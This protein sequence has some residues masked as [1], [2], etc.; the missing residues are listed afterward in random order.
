MPG[1]NNECN[2]G[3][4]AAVGMFLTEVDEVILLGGS[5]PSEGSPCGRHLAAECF[6]P[7]VQRPSVR[8]LTHLVDEVT[9]C[10][11]EYSSWKA[12]ALR[13]AP[14]G[15]DR[16]CGRHLADGSVPPGDPVPAA[17]G[18]VT[19]PNGITAKNLTEDCRHRPLPVYGTFVLL[20]SWRRRRTPSNYIS[21]LA[22]PS[23]KAPRC[24]KSSRHRRPSL[25]IPR[26]RSPTMTAST[27]PW[28]SRRRAMP[29]ASSRSLVPK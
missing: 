3:G 11:R 15:R 29:R 22:S 16:P 2:P 8:C 20:R 7:K 6:L 28:S 4:N 26:W 17:H 19:F 5:F 25:A 23:S 12:S 13:K 27:A 10:G 21:T 1:S 9:T 24:L 14:P 18:G